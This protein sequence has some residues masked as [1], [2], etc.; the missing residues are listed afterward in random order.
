MGRI[1]R[2][3]HQKGGNYRVRENSRALQ[4]GSL[5][6]L[7]EYFYEHAHEKLFQADERTIAKKYIK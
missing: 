1:C 3:K 4:K 6:A 5:K 2:E 7:T